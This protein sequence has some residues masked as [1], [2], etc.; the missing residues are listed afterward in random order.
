MTYTCQACG[1]EV[2]VS[3][4]RSHRFCGTCRGERQRAAK[5][6]WGDRKRAARI[7]LRHAMDWADREVFEII[8]VKSASAG[9]RCRGCGTALPSLRKPGRPRLWCSEACRMRIAGHG[10]VGVSGYA[11]A[12]MADPCAYCSQPSTELDHVYASA[13]GGD[14]D[15]SNLAGICSSCNQQKSA[16]DPL[17]YML[18]KPLYTQIDA[19]RAALAELRV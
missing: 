6:A 8:G 1:A 18:A 3:V 2:E 5:K 4:K 16:M 14:G 9:K 7:E 15:W 12:L 17:R 13:R 19:A 11:G 10:N